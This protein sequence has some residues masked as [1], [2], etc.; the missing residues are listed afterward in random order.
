MF[1]SACG[2]ENPNQ[3]NYCTNCGL[4][5]Q[6]D[7][8]SHNSHVA[9]AGFWKRF[10]ANLSDSVILGIAGGVLEAIVGVEAGILA[11]IVLYWLYFTL[12]ESSSKQASL[13]KMLLGI[14][15]TDME[16]Q[17]LTFARANARYWTKVLSALILGIGFMMAGFTNR[18][19]ALHDMIAET[20]VVTKRR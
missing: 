10:L 1:C 11:G 12:L 8:L 14:L 4:P 3:D 5:F 13:G 20:L 2:V 18:K 19:Q 7:L 16:G 9:Y 17:R 15:V 6:Q